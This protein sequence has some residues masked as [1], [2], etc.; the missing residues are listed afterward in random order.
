MK[1]HLLVSVLACLALASCSSGPGGFGG[2]SRDRDRPAL[3]P[4]GDPGRV[5]AAEVAYALAAREEGQWTAM[6]R[7]AASDALIHISSGPV[8]VDEFLGDAADPAVSAGW[9]PR[10]V[11]S[12][13]DGSLALT[14]GRFEDPSGIVGSFAQ[15]WE[16]QSNREYRWTYNLAVIDDPQPEP[17]VEI[18]PDENTIVVVEMDSIRG[19]VADCPDRSAPPVSRPVGRVLQSGELAGSEAAN[20]DSLRILWNHL[21]DSSRSVWIEWLNDGEWQEAMRLTAP[22]ITSE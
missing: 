10:E 1:N 6:R 16:L 11:W 5:A 22:D 18:E 9:A 4:I 12:S 19:H 17:V 14:F 8:P 3:R 15:V 20:D 21:P 13:C 7:F 2:G